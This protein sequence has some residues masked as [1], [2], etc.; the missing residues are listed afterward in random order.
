MRSS[1]RATIRLVALSAVLAAGAL[2]PGVADAQPV[3][4]QQSAVSP[5]FS[6]ASFPLLSGSFNAVSDPGGANP[7]GQVHYTM[8]AGQRVTVQAS[9]TCLSVSGNTAVIGFQGARFFFVDPP[10]P[11]SG[12]LVVADNGP[13]GSPSLDTVALSERVGSTSPPNCSAP[14]PV[15]WAYFDPGPLRVYGDI[16]VTAALPG[17][18]EQCKDGLWRDFGLFKNQGDCVSFMATGGRNAPA[19]E[20]SP[21]Q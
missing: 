5:G 3:A 19:N 4:R 2:G 8:G 9:V 17:S 10:G 20:L 18:T 14:G 13:A 7:S 15:I 21:S 1:R 6:P 12:E 11:V 16:I